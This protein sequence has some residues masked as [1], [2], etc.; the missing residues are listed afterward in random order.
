MPK[1]T[2]VSEIDVLTFSTY[3][4]ISKCILHGLPNANIE[5]DGTLSSRVFSVGLVLGNLYHELLKKLDN[6][7]GLDS[8]EASEKLSNY[9]DEYASKAERLYGTGKS[10][11]ANSFRL[12]REVNDI[13]LSVWQKYLEQKK[14]VGRYIRE[15]EFSSDED[16][17]KGILD[18][19]YLED[20]RIRLVVLRPSLFRPLCTD[21][22]EVR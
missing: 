16:R 19:L 5:V 14:G 12:R 15:E 22:F 8:E 18:E 10:S 21:L 1:V 2:S 11:P 6:L 20:G 17:L 13:Y 4:K 7:E 9:L 3:K